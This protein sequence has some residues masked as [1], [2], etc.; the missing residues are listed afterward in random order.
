MAIH[1]EA[2]SGWSRAC[3]RLWALLLFTTG[4]AHADETRFKWTGFYAGAHTGAAMDYSDFSNPY[5]ANLFG[6]ETRSPGPFL[7]GQI[8]YNYQDGIAVYGLQAD[9]TWANMQGT[10]TCMQPAHQLPAMNPAFV[11]GAFG[12]TC[13]TEPDWFGTLTA[14]AGLA[15]GPQ[16]RMLVYGKGGLAW[17]HNDVE[18]AQNNMLAPAA[19]PQDSIQTTKY[20]QWGW[21]L[22][23]GLEYA[24]TSRWSLG[25]EYDYLGFGDRSVATSNGQ[26]ITGTGIPGVTGST[27]TDGR[28]ASVSQDVHAAKLVVNYALDDRRVPLDPAAEP[29]PLASAFGSGLQVEIGGRY[30]YGW[31]R[32]QQDLGKST[33]AL[34]TNISRLTWEG[35]GTGGYELYGRLDTP[36]DFV[37]KGFVGVGRGSSGKIYDEDWGLSDPGVTDVTPYQVTRS[38]ISSSLD[39][40]TLDGGYDLVRTDAYRVTPFIGWNYFRYK[41]NA[42]GCTFLQ[43]SPAQVCD[44]ADPPT[45]VFLQEMDTW[46]SLRLGTSAELML[47]SRLKLTGDVAYLPYVNYRGVDNHP[48][49]TDST[50]G[51]TRSPQHGAGTGVQI[52]G[53]VSYDI[54]EQ[55]SIGASGRF[56]SMGVPQGLTNFFSANAFQPERFTTEHTAVFAQGSYKFN[57][58]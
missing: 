54:T 34:P 51:T 32:F 47:T 3:V 53:V 31:S 16:G 45:A 20:I 42:L 22:G 33:A 15:L 40:F 44:A 29:P 46:R 48:R 18:I 1:S 21:T 28:P 52:E 6:G 24:L 30:V 55:F 57:A 41:M 36:W 5:G 7:G 10:A 2:Q 43:L 13:Q 12:A 9:A 17:I 4:A 35:A 58:D 37:L 19:G 56:W 38:D 14:R 11:G 23:A 50:T 26:P 27:A 49:R 39:Y 8:G 25:F